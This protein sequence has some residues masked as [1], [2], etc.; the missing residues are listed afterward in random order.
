MAE[1]IDNKQVPAHRLTTAALNALRQYDWPGNLEQLRSII[2]SLALTADSDDIDAPE[3][4]KVLAQFRQENH[5]KNPA[6][7]SI[8]CCA[9]CA[10]SWSGA[11][12]N[13]TLAWK[14][15]YEPGGAKVGLERTHLYRKL[16]QWASNSAGVAPKTDLAPGVRS[17]RRAHHCGKFAH[18]QKKLAKAG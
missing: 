16:K 11:T 2:K 4:N 8:C 12:S 7:T 6:L 5:Q 3:V 18:L 17:A 13:I 9:S 10:S 1:L 15:Q 14:R